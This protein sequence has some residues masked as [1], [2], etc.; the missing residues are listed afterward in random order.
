MR[1][2]NRFL[3]LTDIGNTV[4]IRCAARF[5]ICTSKR[6][7]RRARAVFGLCRGLSGSIPALVSP[8][9][10][11]TIFTSPYD[12]GLSDTF[13]EERLDE[14]EFWWPTMFSPGAILR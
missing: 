10:P 6:T 14:P 1:A 11:E 13:L 3:S 2:S 7:A 4:V 12:M 9:N 5:S 8:R